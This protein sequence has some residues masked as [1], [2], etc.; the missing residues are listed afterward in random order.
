MIINCLKN[1]IYC[2]YPK[3]INNITEKEKY[4]NSKEFINLSNLLNSINVE[5]FTNKLET[6]IKKNIFFK[7]IQNR[8]SL[9]FDR[10]IT[11]ELEI[12][13]NDKLIRF[14]IELSVLFPY[15]YIYI[16]EN[17]IQNKPYMWMSLPIRNNELERKYQ[18]EI[19]MLKIIIEDETGYFPIFENIKDVKINDLYFQDVEPENFTIYNAFFKDE[20]I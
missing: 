10:C 14:V 6:E 3:G 7:N 17:I 5:T 20:Q 4:L 18:S 8:T 16:T 1:I 12:I 19:N 11:F 13:K 2:Y 9:S 15:Y